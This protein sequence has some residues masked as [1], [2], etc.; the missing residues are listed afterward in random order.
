MVSS[1]QGHLKEPVREEYP[2]VASFMSQSYLKVTKDTDIY[3]VMSL[4]LKEHVSGALVVEGDQLLGIVTEKDLLRLARQDTYSSAPTGGPA[5]AYMTTDLVTISPEQGLDETADIFLNNVYKK[6]PVLDHGKLVG[7]VR[8]RDVLKIIEE[9]YQ[10]R[11][12]YLREQ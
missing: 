1:Y 9:F 6:L 7:V 8:R 3:K 11:M 2:S 10:R 5:S 12:N 4:V